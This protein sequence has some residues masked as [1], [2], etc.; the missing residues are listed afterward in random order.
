MKSLN[1]NLATYH[2]YAVFKN[3]K[4]CGKFVFSV[5]RMQDS[6]GIM[7]LQDESGN[8]LYFNYY[9]ATFTFH[10]LEGKSSSLLKMLFMA[11]PR[12]PMVNMK[13]FEW[14]DFLPIALTGSRFE[15]FMFP[16]TS[17]ISRFN[18][19]AKGTWR[20]DNGTISGTISSGK[21][22]LQTTAIID[23]LKGILNIKIKNMELKK[24]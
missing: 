23:P 1:L 12:L 10:E 9:N 18:G 5:N 15:R 4:E 11:I 22:T 13:Q 24:L 19:C 2:R 6:S 17:W 14:D 20:Y 7:F 21:N 16:I 8:R 3:G